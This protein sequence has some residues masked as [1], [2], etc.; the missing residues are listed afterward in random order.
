MWRME[1][2]SGKSKRS[3]VATLSLCAVWLLV[4]ILS[5]DAKAQLTQTLFSDSFETYNTD[6]PLP[7]QGG[8]FQDSTFTAPL[9]LSTTTPFAPSNAIDGLHRTGTGA[10]DD[11][12]LAAARHTLSGPLNPNGISIFSTDAYAFSAHQSHA[13]GISF[14]SADDN[15]TNNGIQFQASWYPSQSPNW[16]FSRHLDGAGVSNDFISGSFDQPVHLEIIVDGANGVYYGRLTSSAGVFETAHHPITTAEISALSQVAVEEDFRDVYLGVDIT[17]MKV[18]TG[19]SYSVCLLYDPTRSVHSGATLPLKFYLC[20]ANGNDVSTSNIVVH[21]V[22]LIQT[23]TN[24]S[25]VIQD[26]GNSNPDNDFRFDYTLGTS[27]GYIFNLK[28]TGLATGSY[29]L[30][31]STGNDPLTHVLNFQ[32]R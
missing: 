9:M 22:R 5:V 27:G 24:A 30:T 17:N 2:S 13:S 19:A 18:T 10:Y 6:S 12:S 31:V 3:T 25:E 32:V 14:S 4:M 23:S 1:S 8:W 26:A 29:Q 7:G 28:T 16:E 21:A 11:T 20:D 15:W